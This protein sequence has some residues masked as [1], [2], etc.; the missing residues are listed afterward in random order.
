M[1][2]CLYYAVSRVF[3]SITSPLASAG[4]ESLMLGSQHEGALPKLRQLEDKHISRPEVPDTVV[5]EKP[6]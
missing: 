2:L 5:T 4:R 6:R 1:S 3:L